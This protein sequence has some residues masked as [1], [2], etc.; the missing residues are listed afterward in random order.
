MKARAKNITRSILR[1]CEI[2][3]FFAV[4]VMGYGLLTKTSSLTSKDKGRNYQ[5]GV[6]VCI[7]LPKAGMSADLTLVHD[8]YAIASTELLSGHVFDGVH[9]VAICDIRQTEQVYFADSFTN[10]ASAI[11]FNTLCSRPF[12]PY[13]LFQENPVLLI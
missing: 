3:L 7:D 1:F 6:S 2:A 11:T 4:S 10:S 12:Q 8:L 9:T 5:P 13:N